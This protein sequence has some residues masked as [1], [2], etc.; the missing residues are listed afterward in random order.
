M[1]TILL[2]VGFEVFERCRINSN[3]IGLEQS[4]LLDVFVWGGVSMD[5]GFV[6][7]EA[8]HKKA[9]LLMENQWK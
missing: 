2:L 7:S 4:P 1:E 8:I 9:T 5:L 6:D 3:E